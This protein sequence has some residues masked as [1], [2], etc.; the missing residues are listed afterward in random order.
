MLKCL[1]ISILTSRCWVLSTPPE[2]VEP[3]LQRQTFCFPKEWLNAEILE[4]DA[5]HLLL[6]FPRSWYLQQSGNLA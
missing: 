5:H 2:Q 3:I 4:E 6:A 1:C